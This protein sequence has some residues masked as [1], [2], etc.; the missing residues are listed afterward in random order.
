MSSTRPCPRCGG[1][2]IRRSRRR[3]FWEHLLSKAG[4]FPY[5][6]R[7]C[8]NRFIRHQAGVG[9]LFAVAAVWVV[10]AAVVGGVAW[11]LLKE[12]AASGSSQ[13][14]AR[15]S[16][17]SVAP[18]QEAQRAVRLQGQN[19]QLRAAL[20]ELR[21]GLQ[22][23][24]QERAAL[25]HEVA[26]VRGQLA[27]APPSAPAP[28]QAKQDGRLADLA[29]RNQELARSLADTQ[30]SLAETLSQRDALQKE[31]ARARQGPVQAADP[32]RL[33]SLESANQRLNRNLDQMRSAL[34]AMASERAA[35]QKELERL[36]R[37]AA[38]PRQ[39]PDQVLVATVPFASGRTTLGPKAR[40][41]LSVAVAR[42]KGRPSLIVVVQGNADATPLGPKTARLYFDNA[43]VAMARALSVFRALRDAGVDPKR[44]VVR[45]AGAPALK[46]EAGRT[47]GIWLAGPG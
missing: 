30:R 35:L 36:S 38:E 40:R 44:M 47:V 5:S 19:Q 42:L 26:R 13:A 9:F 18:S 20:A 7:S 28:A 24:V 33:R 2:D 34:G 12:P 43:G 39:G 32:Q 10:A 3:G 15:P 25:Q 29:A 31:L 4:F 37:S 41:L 46:P 11:W 8:R 16:P 17:R 45:A 27:A 6:C 21:R 23:I 1:R 22:E 14:S